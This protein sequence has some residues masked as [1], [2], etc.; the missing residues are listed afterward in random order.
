MDREGVSVSVYFKK[1]F[2][3]CL[4]D[5][6]AIQSS[7]HNS[8]LY[9]ANCHQE[10]HFIINHLRK[11]K[12][13]NFLNTEDFSLNFFSFTPTTVFNSLPFDSIQFI[14]FC[15]SALNHKC[16]EQEASDEKQKKKHGRQ[17]KALNKWVKDTQ[18]H[19][20]HQTK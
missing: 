6:L 12:K 20:Y 15:Y 19:T 4:M 10:C 7:I 17:G 18:T 11:T 13:K 14:C 3:F 1:I 2:F 8:R 9:F 5:S 16:Y